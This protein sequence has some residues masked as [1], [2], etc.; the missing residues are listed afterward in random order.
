MWKS[1]YISVSCGK[2]AAGLVNN[3]ASAHTTETQYN[4]MTAEHR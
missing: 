2:H 1:S 3:K 4:V